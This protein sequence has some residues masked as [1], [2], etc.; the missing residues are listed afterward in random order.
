MVDDDKRE[1][2]DVFVKI[3]NGMIYEQIK[4]IQFHMIEIEKELHALRA[5]VKQ[6]NTFSSLNR[7]WLWV[8]TTSIAGVLA[9]IINLVLN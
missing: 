6:M 1:Q 3:T 4:G 2:G 9:F 8:A 5:E 7:K